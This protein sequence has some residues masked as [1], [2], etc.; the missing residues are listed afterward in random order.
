M[1]YIGLDI[2]TSMIKGQLL[3]DEGIILSTCKFESPTYSPDGIFYLNAEKLKDIIFTII[4]KLVAKSDTAI[5]SICTSTLGEAFVLLDNKGNPLND[6][7][8]FTSNLG[9]KEKDE[10]LTK[11]DPLKVADISGLYPNKMFSFSK[12]QFGKSLLFKFRYSVL[13]SVD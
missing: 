6:F 1:S 12:F 4:K 3:N 5:K 13:I 7:I 11:I 10:L 9:E 8:L 2:G